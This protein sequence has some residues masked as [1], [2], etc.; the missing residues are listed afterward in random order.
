MPRYVCS[1]TIDFEEVDNEDEARAEFMS[2]VHSDLS[3][4]EVEVEVVDE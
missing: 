4:H 3:A 2:Y 1:V